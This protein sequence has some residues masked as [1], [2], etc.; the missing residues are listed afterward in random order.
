MTDDD[1]EA[2]L[3][4]V[5]KLVGFADSA[6]PTCLTKKARRRE[7][8]KARR[9]EEIYDGKQSSPHEV[10]ASFLCLRGKS[11]WASGVTSEQG[12]HGPPRMTAAC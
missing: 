5:E 6:Y 1:D 9:H 7:G 10:R 11:E 3:L 2:G 8:K 12:G 4:P